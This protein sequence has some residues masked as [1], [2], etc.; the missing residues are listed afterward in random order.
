V[1]ESIRSGSHVGTNEILWTKLLSQRN[2]NTWRKIVRLFFDAVLEAE[3]DAANSYNGVAIMVFCDWGK[4]RSVAAMLL[5]LWCCY[6][7]SWQ[8]SQDFT[9]C[10]TRYWSVWKC[11][12]GPPCAGCDTHILNEDNDILQ[13]ALSIFRYEKIMMMEN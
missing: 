5:L 6:H 1:A 9:N 13:E 4:H 3:P 8:V 12:N 7:D 11:G 10:S 2:F